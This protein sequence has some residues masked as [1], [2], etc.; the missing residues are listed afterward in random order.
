MT[1]VK[2]LS[3]DYA[4]ILERMINEFCQKRLVLDIKFST[5]AYG[6][7]VVYS[8]MVTYEGD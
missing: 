2:I 7:I 4:D 5:A 3:A 8:A 1:K 6:R